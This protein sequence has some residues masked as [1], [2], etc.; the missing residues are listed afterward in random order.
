M[1]FTG[2]RLVPTAAGYDDLFLEHVSRYAFAS[3]LVE[4]RRVLDAGCGCGYGSYH[5]ARS[6]ALSVLGIDVSEEAVRYCEEHYRRKN[7][8]FR[9]GD[10]LDTGL[11]AESFDVVVAFEVFEHLPDP[12]AFLAEME[13][14]LKPDGVLV[15][16]TP[17]ANTYAA[18]GEGGKNPFHVTEYTPEEFRD[19]L[20]RRFGAIYWYAQNRLGGISVAPAREGDGRTT[21]LT[22]AS[23]V[24]PPSESTWGSLAPATV[25]LDRCAYLIAVCYR[26]DVGLR[27]LPGARL[28]APSRD[29]GFGDAGALAGQKD[30]TIRQLQAELESRTKWAE[31]LKREL[32][33]RDRTIRRMQEEFEERTEWALKLDREVE[34]QRRLIEAW[35]Q[36]GSEPVKR[37]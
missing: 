13:R 17:N 18:G 33:E 8:S 37:P 36:A 10:V 21:V 12:V 23:V 1:D 5:L 35:R 27:S 34:E 16:S 30:E 9:V 24:L 29:S 11:E 4:G 22:E 14:L 3:A 31:S 26:Q 6:R 32:E 15:L 28:Y 19:L 7:L 25:S 2:E 20:G